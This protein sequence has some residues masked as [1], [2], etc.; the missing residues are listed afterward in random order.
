M[1]F[2]ASALLIVAVCLQAVLPAS[3]EKTDKL[4][5]ENG[6][7]VTGEIKELTRGVLR[8]K[9][10]SMDTVIVKWKD[11]VRL[12]SGH[13]FEIELEDGRRF[14]GRLG[15][16]SEDRVLRVIGAIVDVEIPLMQTVRILLIHDTFWKRVD[17]ALKMGYSFTKA[18]E[19]TQVNASANATYRAEL[20]STGASFSSVLTSQPGKTTSRADLNADY[21]RQLRRAGFATAQTGLQHNDELGIDLR[22]LTAGSYGRYA[23][24]T[25]RNR[26]GASAG[27][28]FNQERSTDGTSKSNLEV[29]IAITY[30]RFRFETP[31]V[32][33]KSVLNVFP[34]LTDW[35][36]WRVEYDSS[37]TQEIIKDFVFD[38]SLYYS[39]DGRPQD[40]E[41][42]N[43]DY[44][45]TTSLGWSF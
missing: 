3:A 2:R 10:D 36:R 11:V 26:L 43:V 28:A 37:W 40:V 44:G 30:D 45:I 12:T 1:T 16:P 7:V 9:T 5:L 18:S 39:F 24:R 22:F 41:A 29:L 27:L 17:G 13:Q 8:Y 25:N 33:L 34:S 19:V 42:A 14:F 4:T 21:R 32:D 6:D 15:E 20:Y 31:K 23:I 35:G 38:L